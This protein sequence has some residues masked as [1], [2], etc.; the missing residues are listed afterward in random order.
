MS[1]L[2]LNLKNILAPSL[3]QPGYGR[4]IDEQFNAIM[5][6]FR[7]V[8]NRDF[9]KGD[10]GYSVCV[11]DCYMINPTQNPV[12]GPVFTELGFKVLKYIIAEHIQSGTLNDT[13]VDKLWETMCKNIS[14]YDLAEDKTIS[15]QDA[16]LVL[17]T[18]EATH[19][20]I[21]PTTHEV[22][23]MIDF[24]V[25]ANPVLKVL[26]TYDPVATNKVYTKVGA[27]NNIIFKDARFNIKSL[28][29][30]DLS[31]YSSMIDMS[32]SVHLQ[33]VPKDSMNAAKIEIL[34]DMPTLYYNSSN[35]VNTFCWMI[36][37]QRTGM[38]AQGPSGHNGDNANFHILYTE[39]IDGKSDYV[40]TKFASE[41]N[42]WVDIDDTNIHLF[43]P[44]DS[45]ILFVDKVPLNA[46]FTKKIYISKVLALTDDSRGIHV[47]VDEE[48]AIPDMFVADTLENI[49]TSNI[50]ANSI[51]RGLHVPYET[52]SGSR[53]GY[54]HMMWSDG[55]SASNT[56][57]NTLHLS[58]LHYGRQ[59]G[60]DTYKNT[61]LYNA[62]GALYVDYETIRFGITNDKSDYIK[63][64]NDGAHSIVV[65]AT[66]D[67]TKIRRSS[68]RL[69]SGNE[70]LTL[71]LNAYNDS[72]YWTLDNGLVDGIYDIP[73]DRLCRPFHFETGQSSISAS[74]GGRV[75]ISSDLNNL[76]E[77]LVLD[78]YGLHQTT[79]K[80]PGNLK[81]QQFGGKITSYAPITFL[82][83]GYFKKTLGVEGAANI[84]G[85]MKAK[86]ISATQ[87]IVASD[88]GSV[89]LTKWGTIELTR[90]KVENG[91]YI[92]SH[93]N[94]L[95]IDSLGLVLAQPGGNKFDKTLSISHQINQYAKT[96]NYG[97]MYSD[98]WIY[99]MKPQAHGTIYNIDAMEIA[100]KNNGLDSSGDLTKFPNAITIVIGSSTNRV[101]TGSG[102]GDIIVR[103][104]NFPGHAFVQ[105]HVEAYIR[106]T[107]KN[108]L[109]VH[110]YDAGGEQW[111]TSPNYK[112]ADYKAYLHY[113]TYTAW[114]PEPDK[115]NSN[116]CL[117][118]MSPLF[119][120]ENS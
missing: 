75:L 91:T 104:T 2:D 110:I 112:A 80:K 41:N 82:E 33:S 25:S 56:S 24:F 66:T 95:H 13:I 19:S 58:P 99:D 44:G 12:K 71:S 106:H 87:V 68:I 50:S 81:L 74:V 84:N 40:V 34:H 97:G 30:G 108:D 47:V 8:G 92:N 52:N 39:Y 23:N 64:I 120:I 14:R 73:N 27:I 43:N 118:L 88:D 77:R 32:C 49:L 79:D 3:S 61:P 63:F 78:E 9:V 115:E 102:A 54:R 85:S 119:W 62:S 113:L 114:G 86:D 29:D 67:N 21:D 18:R 60:L 31:R 53:Q 36:G 28:A 6:N 20:V 101:I 94:I 111:H 42:N 37:G 59:L 45:C 98:M 90:G 38:L 105:V 116:T 35:G 48:R 55:S 93:N 1:E 57:N 10:R 100:K 17:D 96:C 46:S 15:V 70:F 26:E 22:I 5:E 16:C 11:E 83:D 117:Q 103:L 107:G 109:D 72:P 7:L 69:T 65:G 89:T 76:K 4:N 51:L